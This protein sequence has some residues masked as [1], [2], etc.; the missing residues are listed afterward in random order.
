[1]KD[2]IVHVSSINGSEGKIG[3]SK[4]RRRRSSGATHK[5]SINAS[6]ETQPTK[7]RPEII[8]D[9]QSELPIV[10]NG[11]VT[12]DHVTA[13]PSILASS[14]Q[15]E[16]SKKRIACTKYD[17]DERR[18]IV[19]KKLADENEEN[20]GNTASLKLQKSNAPSWIV[21]AL[22]RKNSASIV[23]KTDAEKVSSN[24]DTKGS[25]IGSP[26]VKLRK[27]EA[28]VHIRFDKLEDDVQEEDLH[29]MSKRK[30]T[31][32]AAVSSLDKPSCNVPTRAS[33]PVKTP[34]KPPPPSSR[35]QTSNIDRPPP[36]PTPYPHS[37][38]WQKPHSAPIPPRPPPP[39]YPAPPPTPDSVEHAELNKMYTPESSSFYTFCN[40]GD[41]DDEVQMG[42]EKLYP[43]G[44][45]KRSY[46]VITSENAGGSANKPDLNI[47]GKKVS[48]FYPLKVGCKSF[49]N[50][51]AV[52]SFLVQVNDNIA[53][54]TTSLDET[55]WEPTI[56]GPFKVSAHDNKLIYWLQHLLTGY[57]Y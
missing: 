49:S 38:P 16:V 55:N 30:K 15:L 57:G 20:S 27:S 29:E 24:E 14:Q 53:F 56:A 3:K 51:F 33:T 10:T 5:S 50:C 25:C 35:G 39:P 8:G 41:D 44:K 28:N 18:G 48:Q 4:K 21:S 1:M 54:I 7:S 9:K 34:P 40:G 19:S 22:H 46:F 12:A 32:N 43:P 42:F 23:S 47:V 36:P 11:G 31:S 45:K 2:L 13:N 26:T 17:N 6:M 37:S 52:I